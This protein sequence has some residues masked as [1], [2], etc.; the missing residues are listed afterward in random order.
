MSATLQ[1]TLGKYSLRPYHLGMRESEYLH[2]RRPTHLMVGGGSGLRE[3][4]EELPPITDTEKLS[5]IIT[6]ARHNLFSTQAIHPLKFI[7]DSIKVDRQKLTI[8]HNEF[9]R[10]SQTASIQ[11]RDIMNIQADTGPLFGNITV[12]SK[13]FLNNTQTIKFLRRRDVNKI[14]RLVQGLMIA[15][16]SGIKT[17]NI[18]DEHLLPM[19]LELGEANL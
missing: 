18:D 3:V 1:I 9:L 16:R 17:D 5:G 8:V 12:T 10:S 2:Y 6:G 19:L 14:Q 11:I 15:N 13:Y 4:D 7:A